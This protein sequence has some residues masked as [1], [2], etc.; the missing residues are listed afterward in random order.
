LND[1][2]NDLKKMGVRGW[3]KIARDRFTW[4]LIA[5]EVKVL[6]GRYSLCR[7]RYMILA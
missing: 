7:R 2:E 4:K 1:V 5:K 6:Y 3:R